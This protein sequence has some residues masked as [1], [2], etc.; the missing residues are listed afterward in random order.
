MRDYLS[1]LSTLALLLLCS[2]AIVSAG[3]Y[4]VASLDD[5][6][7]LGMSRNPRLTESARRI[8]EAQEGIKRNRALFYPTAS[9]MTGLYSRDAVFTIDPRLLQ[10]LEK[11]PGF[12]FGYTGEIYARFQIDQSIYA[13]GR[14]MTSL[15]LAHREQELQNERD[16]LLRLDLGVTITRQYYAVLLAQHVHKIKQEL[17]EQ[18]R[19]HLADVEKRLEAGDVSRFDLLRAQVQLANLTPEE[20]RARNDVD[21]AMAQLKNTL[22]VAQT[23]AL[24]VSGEIECQPERPDLSTAVRA[25]AENRPELRIARLTREIRE[26]SERV[27]RAGYKPTVGAFFSEELRSDALN[28]LFTDRHSN[29]TFGLLVT[30]PVLNIPSFHQAHQ[31]KLKAAQA[32]IQEDQAWR[33][34]E[35]EVIQAGLELQRAAEVIESQ[36]HNVAQAQEA[37]AIANISYANGVVTNLELMD[38]QIALE[39]ARIH[40][41]TAVHDYLVGWALYKKAIGEQP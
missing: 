18:N 5:A 35:V 7:K 37:I 40:Y 39:E 14:N 19:R 12:W 8:D 29:W 21:L 34:I 4:T 3:D 28:T 38:T 17:I 2:A 23:D 1:V 31:E 25:A 16:R 36:K 27:A 41:V 33:D 32:R 26:Q 22:G 11:D 6:L 10:G 30:V 13:G 9:F 24:A 15:R 20:I